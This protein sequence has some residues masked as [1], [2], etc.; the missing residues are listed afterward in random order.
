MKIR[1]TDT[2]ILNVDE[3]LIWAR[4]WDWDLLVHDGLKKKERLVRLGKAVMTIV[5]LTSSSLLENLR[6]LLGWN[7]YRHDVE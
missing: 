6:P 1:V 5:L 2:G 3:N 4:L 7:L